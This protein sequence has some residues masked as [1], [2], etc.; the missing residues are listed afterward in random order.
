MEKATQK[1]SHV[2]LLKGRR[3]G[4][5]ER[6]EEALGEEEEEEEKRGWEQSQTGLALDS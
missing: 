1:K 2:P 3:V 4:R 5:V 6:G